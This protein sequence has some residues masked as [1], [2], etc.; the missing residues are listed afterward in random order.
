MIDR[1][2]SCQPREW[3]PPARLLTPSPPTRRVARSVSIAGDTT[4]LYVVGNDVLF[5]DQPVKVGEA[6]TAW[7]VGHGS[8]G[9]PA[10]DLAFV[11]PRAVVDASGRLHVLWGEPSTDAK[12]IAPYKW[13]LLPIS[14]I[15]SATYEPARG[16][17]HPARIHSGPVDWNRATVGAVSAEAKH[18]NLVVAP[19]D[20]GGV[21]LLALRD[22]RWHATTVLE[23]LKPA[24]ASVIA[25]VGRQ[26]LSIVAAST[27]DPEDAA[28]GTFHD[29]N[30][31]LLYSQDRR[32]AWRPWKRIQRSGEQPAFELALLEGAQGR[33]HLLWRQTIRQDYFVIRHVHSDDGGA[34]WTEPSDLMPGGPVQNV[35]AAVEACGRLH[36]VY[37]D[38]SEGA[39]AVRIGYATWDS[40]WSSPRRLH[41]QYVIAEAGLHRRTDGALLV[42][43]LGTPHDAG[44]RSE[45]AMLY[46][47]F[48]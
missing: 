14:S 26:L 44:D 32:G 20:A 24:Y 21:L 1:P 46:S 27:P 22:G 48:R 36:V 4:D 29:V 8:I 19:N 30:S 47:E 10:P 2:G 12:E 38:W 35:Q 45:W 42:T 41:A 18:E 16:W 40:T 5:L 7:R 28:K 23:N 37:E 11:S 6:L 9:A 34:S 31:V 13:A 17:S 15:W 43:F 33:V 25:L 3:T 39:D